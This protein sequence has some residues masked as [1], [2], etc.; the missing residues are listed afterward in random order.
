MSKESIKL[1]TPRGAAVYPAIDRKDTK[2]DDNGVWKADIAL[3]KEAAEPLIKKL[4]AIFKSH[5]GKVA[6]V[7][8]NSMFYKE[9]DKETGEE[10]GRVI[11]KLRVKDRVLKDGS[12]WE[13]QPKVFDG[14]GQLVSPIPAIGGGSE[15]KVRFE[16]Y[17]WDTGANKGVSIQ[18]T[19][20][21]LLKLVE[22]TAGE[23][24]PFDEEP[25]ADFYTGE[26][27][28]DDCPFDADESD[29]SEGAGSGD[30]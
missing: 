1:M 8:K 17:C 26:D 20:I 10:T 16:V 21:Q 29:G 6:P 18:P 2:F 13:R 23:T 25:D 9:T 24:S 3:S 12:P 14:A 19:D 27:D 11:F 22:R 5:T 15:Y 30:F 4:Q 7:S 28:G